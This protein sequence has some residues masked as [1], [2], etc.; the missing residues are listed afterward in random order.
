MEIDKKFN[1]WLTDNYFGKQYFYFR[2][3][4]SSDFYHY[5][6]FS[7]D[8]FRPRK[9]MHILKKI[10][11]IKNGIFNFFGH[12]LNIFRCIFRTLVNIQDGAV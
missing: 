1:I 6:L 7:F 3:F 2:I 11:E 4:I 10:H 9:L 5:I 8:K 12:F